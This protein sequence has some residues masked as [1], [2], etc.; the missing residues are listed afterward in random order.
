V[1][2]EKVQELV[3]ASRMEKTTE[4]GSPVGKRSGSKLIIMIGVEREKFSLFY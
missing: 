3:L 2:G 4:V 1:D